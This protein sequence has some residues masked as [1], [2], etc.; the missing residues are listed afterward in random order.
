MVTAGGRGGGD[1][2]SC[3]DGSGVVAS[4][5]EKVAAGDA[6]SSWWIDI[7]RYRMEGIG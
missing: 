7:S 1:R 3:G 2:G 5:W 6:A 4:G